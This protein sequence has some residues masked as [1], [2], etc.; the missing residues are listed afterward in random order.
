MASLALGA[1][2]NLVVLEGPC[3]NP[4]GHWP[5]SVLTSQHF[6]SFDR[7]LQFFKDYGLIPLIYL[8]H[9]VFL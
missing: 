7:L 8:S 4:S 5:W 2:V 6:I 1:M 9:T 3:K